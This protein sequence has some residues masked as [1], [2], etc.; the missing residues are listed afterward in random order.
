MW[1]FGKRAL[2][3][4]RQDASSY[5]DVVIRALVAAA[6]GEEQD[7][8]HGTAA[9][10][11]AAS[12]YSRAFLMAR[13]SP[14]SAATKAGHAVHARQRRARDGDQGASRCI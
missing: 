8:A 5:T 11:T 1:P 6:T 7:T 13:I 2:V 10:E 12:L 9:A 14:K 4:K 3:E